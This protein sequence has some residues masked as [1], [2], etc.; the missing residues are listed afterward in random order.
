[1][2]FPLIPEIWVCFR[3]KWV[4]ATQKP[5]KWLLLEQGCQGA[6]ARKW[7]REMWTL[8]LSL[9]FRN[10]SINVK[11]IVELASCRSLLY[12]PLAWKTNYSGGGM[13]SPSVVHYSCLPCF[14]FKW[15]FLWGTSGPVIP[16][17]LKESWQNMSYL[18]LLGKSPPTVTCPIS[19]EFI[20]YF[21]CLQNHFWGCLNRGKID[22][23]Y[24]LSLPVF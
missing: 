18:Q 1:M 22:E 10:H 7:S 24:L 4:E 11:D 20:A 5:G 16:H 21:L 15:G 23:K 3:E 14:C 6:V 2:T 19:E 8:C 13:A 12:W 9:D 17:L